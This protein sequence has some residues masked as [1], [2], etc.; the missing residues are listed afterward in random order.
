[1]LL[2][3]CLMLLMYSQSVS[4]DWHR[5]MILK[6]GIFTLCDVKS[7]TNSDWF[8]LEMLK[9]TNCVFI[10]KNSQKHSAQWHYAC[11]EKNCVYDTNPL[12]FTLKKNL[13]SFSKSFSHYTVSTILHYAK[14]WCLY[15]FSLVASVLFLMWGKFDSYCVRVL[16]RPFACVVVLLTSTVGAV[17]FR[18]KCPSAVLLLLWQLSWNQWQFSC[19]FHFFPP[20]HNIWKIFKL[21][22]YTGSSN[23]SCE[24]KLGNKQWLCSFKMSGFQRSSLNLHRIIFL[25]TSFYAALYC[26]VFLLE[27]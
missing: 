6:L 23:K 12:Y 1:M 11:I 9:N 26:F 15:L 18:S 14:R 10:F 24:N 7:K 4:G 8:C 21:N 5:T 19:Q 20:T 13:F 22:Q 16:L 17:L 27:H 2:L 25:L 3:C